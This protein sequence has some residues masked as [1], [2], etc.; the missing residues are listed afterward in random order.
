MGKVRSEGGLRLPRHQCEVARCG[1]AWVRHLLDTGADS[2]MIAPRV[3][4]ALGLAPR[5][6]A[7]IRGVTGQATVDVYEIASLEIGGAKVG[8]LTVFA[9][10]TAEPESDGPPRPRLPRSL[11][12]HGRQRRRPGHAHR[13]IGLER[14][15][16]D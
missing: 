10:D 9:H 8:R 11:Q 2:T 16:T 3:P 7:S 1:R 4:R 12:V 14:Q 13:E 15:T 6:T 5:R